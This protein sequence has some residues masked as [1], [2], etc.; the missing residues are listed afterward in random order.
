MK[1]M[2]IIKQPRH[3]I[4]FRILN[5]YNNI[6]FDCTIVRASGYGDILIKMIKM[7]TYQAVQKKLDMMS[8]HI[9][10]HVSHHLIVRIA[11]TALV[12]TVLC[13]SVLKHEAVYSSTVSLC[14]GD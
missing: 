14:T 13:I 8:L 9:T 3:T 4:S 10:L 7:K 6:H 12:L 1:V 11:R 5:F 2:D